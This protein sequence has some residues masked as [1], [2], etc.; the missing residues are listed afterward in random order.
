[1]PIFM[2]YIFLFLVLVLLFY[3]IW[4]I[5]SMGNFNAFLDRWL[6]KTLWIWLPIFAF[7]RLIREV[8]LK[9]KK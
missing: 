1:M 5:L 3:I 2:L 4:D 9:K 7:W 8:I 6:R